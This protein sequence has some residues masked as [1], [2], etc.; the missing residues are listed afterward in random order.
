MLEL[1]VGGGPE[2][3]LIVEAYVPPSQASQV[4]S[5]RP[6]EMDETLGDRG[7]VQDDDAG[8]ETQPLS[9]DPMDED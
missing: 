8:S 6:K 1:F 5:G 7:R 3:D 2:G 4:K 9:D